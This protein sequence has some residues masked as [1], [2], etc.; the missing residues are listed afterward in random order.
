M[1]KTDDEKKK[2]E[3]TTKAAL[4]EKKEEEATTTKMMMEEGQGVEPERRKKDAGHAEGMEAS[5]GHHGFDALRHNRLQR[6]CSPMPG[7]TSRT[8]RGAL[9]V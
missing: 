7:L 5:S 8:G 6:R 3:K 1:D 9:A 2:E 4:E